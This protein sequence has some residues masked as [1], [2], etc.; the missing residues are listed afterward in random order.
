MT[1]ASKP[2]VQS[3]GSFQSSDVDA[4]IETLVEILPRVTRVLKS[5]L[6][7]GKLTPQNMILLTIMQELDAIHED[8]STPGELARKSC[9]SSAAITAALD[10]LVE[11]GFCVR[12]HSEKDRRKVLV[13]VTP[14]G[15]LALAEMRE[16][17]RA[18]LH[19]M[20]SGWNDERATRLRVALEDLDAAVQA[21][22][23]QPRQGADRTSAMPEN[24]RTRA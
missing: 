2:E 23:S 19:R 7:G 17:I 16:S 22:L 21:S 1:L 3:T 20:L 15:R 13:H 11:S 6:R 18:L 14:Y 10:D 9:L 24:E 4:C 8:G 5:Q 12:S